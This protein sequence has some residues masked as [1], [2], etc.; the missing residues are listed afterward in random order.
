MITLQ[1]PSTK[2]SHETPTNSRTVFGN[3]ILN[4]CFISDRKLKIPISFILTE[5]WT[6]IHEFNVC[7]SQWAVSVSVAWNANEIWLTT[8]LFRDGCGLGFP[9]PCSYFWKHNLLRKCKLPGDGQD[10]LWC[11]MG[12]QVW[13]TF[14]KDGKIERAMFVFCCSEESA[15]KAR[16]LFFN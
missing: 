8:P 12:V 7:L 13:A 11:H 6:K 3:L 15:E 5:H 1:T 16:T 9:G 4:A 2:N 10:P 14:L